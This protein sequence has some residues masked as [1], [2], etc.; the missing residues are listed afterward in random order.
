[1]GKSIFYIF[2]VS[3]V[4]AAALYF[5]QGA[6]LSYSEFKKS[7]QYLNARIDTINMKL[8]TI[9]AKID[10]LSLNNDTIKVELR[11]FNQSSS[12]QGNTIINCLKRLWN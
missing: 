2:C 4:V 6:A 3:L 7:E 1:M 5:K 10:R 11:R 9:N 12:E 8:D